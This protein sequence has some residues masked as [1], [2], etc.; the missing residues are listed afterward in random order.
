MTSSALSF[1]GLATGIDSAAIVRNL[2]SLE[3]RPMARL[4]QTKQVLGSQRGRLSAL[5]G[6]LRALG[7][8]AKALGARGSAVPAT[9]GSSDDSVVRATSRG[10]PALGATRVAVQALAQAQRTYSD[11]FAAADVPGLVGTGTLELQVAGHTYTVDIGADDTLETLATKIDATGAPIGASVVFDG[12]GHRLRIAGDATGASQAITFVESGVSLGLSR[13]ESTPRAAADALFTV[14][15][16]A[17]QRSTNV[18]D[19]AV[20]GVRLTLTGVSSPG[21]SAQITVARDEATATARMQK[22]VETYN[23]V[24]RTLDAELAPP[25]AGAPRADSLSADGTLRTVQSRLRSVLGQPI[26]AA[27]AAFRTLSALGVRIERSGTLTLDAAKLESAM[28]A[29]PSAVDRFLNGDDATPGFVGRMQQA[30][31]ALV[32]NPDGLLTRR[33]RSMEGRSRGI[34]DQI[35]RLEL[36]LSKTEELLRSQYATLER[37][38]GGMQAQG[39]QMLAALGQLR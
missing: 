28:A 9:V 31:D 18:V 26:E 11:G 38:V 14:D 2:M 36:R 10:A 35:D 21:A 25:V 13:P 5:S 15:G 4:E 33:M 3:R 19:D 7:D 23:D 30:L 27:P 20:P 32:G 16:L 34:D 12:A 6:K 8:A 37:L 17:M 39:N 1:S 29:D 22:L 24:A